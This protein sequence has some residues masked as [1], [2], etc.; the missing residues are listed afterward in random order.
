MLLT[1][2]SVVL[3]LVMVASYSGAEP[4]DS[5]PSVRSSAVAIPSMVLTQAK[6][7]GEFEESFLEKAYP[8]TSEMFRSSITGSLSPDIYDQ[9]I[10][11]PE[12]VYFDAPIRSGNVA[13]LR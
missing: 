7:A 4:T 10:K 1:R 8:L 2:A 11:K 12:P 9:A 5:Q 6:P 3:A 13:Y